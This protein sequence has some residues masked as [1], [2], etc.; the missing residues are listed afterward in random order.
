MIR[1]PVDVQP[2]D[3][4]VVDQDGNDHREELRAKDGVVCTAGE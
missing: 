3:A 1:L 4:T 2:V